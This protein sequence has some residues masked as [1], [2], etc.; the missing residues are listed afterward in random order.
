MHSENAQ[1]YTV[2]LLLWRWAWCKVCSFQYWIWRQ[3]KNSRE[4]CFISWWLRVLEHVEFIIACQNAL[5]CCRMESSFCMIIPIPI[6]PI[7]WGINVRDLAGKHFNILCTT[8]IFPLVTP[9]FWRPEE[10]HLWTSVS[11]GQGSVRV[12]EVVD[13]SATYLFLQDWNWLSHLPVG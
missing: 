11:F 6:L 13:P 12:D 5:E 3:A 2:V 9:Y 4:V 1:V 10:R 7:W 8:Q